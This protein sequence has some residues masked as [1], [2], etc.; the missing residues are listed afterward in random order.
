[1]IGESE[2]AQPGAVV[3]DLDCYRQRLDERRGA[4]GGKGRHG[5]KYDREGDGAQK[6]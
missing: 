6:E 4:S 2:R 1:V 3:I 5:S